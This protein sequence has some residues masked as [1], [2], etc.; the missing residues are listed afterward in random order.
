M[1]IV[2]I[3]QT[4]TLWLNSLGTEALDPFWKFLS[5]ARVWYPLYGLIMGFII[6]RLGW[7]RGLIVVASLFL[8]V[9]AT[10]QLSGLVKAYFQ[11]L[12]PCFDPWMLEHGVRHPI[13]PGHLYGFFS[14]HASNTFGFAIASYMGLRNDKAHRYTAY[15]WVIM[16]WAA[17]VSLSRVM[18]AAHFVGDI[19]VGAAFGLLIGSLIALM[20]G[21]LCER[22]GVTN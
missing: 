8:A 9:I 21:S 18:L 20:A 11:R 1:S 16:L 14:S 2:E 17:L 4:I 19:L 12:R 3:D 7:K 13:K 5:T 15:A 6:Y 22:V 10:D